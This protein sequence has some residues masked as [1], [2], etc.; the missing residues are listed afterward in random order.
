[1][2]RNVLLIICIIFVMLI[3]IYSCKKESTP[4][5][6]HYYE[7]GYKGNP[8][9]WRDSSFVVATSDTALISK[10]QMQ[11]ALPVAQRQLVS[12]RLIAGNGGYNKNSTH[13]FKWRFKEDDWH[14]ADASIEISDGRPYNDVDLNLNYWLNTVKRF[15]PWG[16]YIK[17]KITLP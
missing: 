12:G 4:A 13:S 3:M 8:A 1:M 17:K 9:D 5:P 15:S 16:S 10:I 11:L 2:N 14:L 7:V 6:L